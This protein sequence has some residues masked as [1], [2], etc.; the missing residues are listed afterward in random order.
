NL[1]IC[2]IMKANRTLNQICVYG[3]VLLQTAASVAQ[4]VTKVAA[5]QAHS[6][7]LKADGSLWGMGYNFSYQLGDGTRNS[8]NRPILMVASNVTAMAGGS[9]H[10]LLAMSNGSLW[11]MGANNA[12]Q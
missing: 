10:T 8:T 4:P 5:G 1:I 11:G 6:L 2:S 7:F 3:A 9:D 12:Y